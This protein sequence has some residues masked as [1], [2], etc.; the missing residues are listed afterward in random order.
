MYSTLQRHSILKG[1]HGGLDP[2]L[3]HHGHQHP[4]NGRNTWKNWD[5]LRV[6]DIRKEKCHHYYRQLGWLWTAGRLWTFFQ[7]LYCLC[8]KNCAS[9]SNLYSHDYLIVK[10]FVQRQ[11]RGIEK[12]SKVAQLTVLFFL[13]ALFMISFT[14][15]KG[16]RLVMIDWTHFYAL[17]LGE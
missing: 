2:P 12:L 7:H 3:S 15:N 4:Q 17:S 16:I 14:S 10:F 5:W 1:T 9:V 11:Y 8:T 6:G 13:I